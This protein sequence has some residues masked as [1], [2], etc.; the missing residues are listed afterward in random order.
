MITEVKPRPY[1]YQPAKPDYFIKQKEAS[2]GR[3]L[4]Q[5]YHIQVPLTGVTLR[6]LFREPQKCE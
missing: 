1:L 2:R 5:Q 3:K 6:I 4:R